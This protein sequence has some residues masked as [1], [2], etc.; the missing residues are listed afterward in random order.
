VEAEVS[1]P[2]NASPTKAQDEMHLLHYQVFHPG[3]AYDVPRLSYTA[4]SNPT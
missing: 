3:E 1:L 4:F 2:K